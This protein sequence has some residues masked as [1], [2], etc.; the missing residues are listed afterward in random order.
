MNPVT[1]YFNAEKFE[2][3][4]FIGIGI[5]AIMIGVILLMY[6][7][8]PF[9]RGISIP[10]IVLAIAQVIVGATVYVRSPKDMAR[11]ESIVKLEKSKLNTEEIPRMKT[12]MKNFKIYRYLE[13]SFMIVGLLLMFV[14]ND[15]SFKQGI[16]LGIFMQ[17]AL[18]LSLDFFAERRG[19]EY[20]HYLSSISF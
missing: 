6:V 12:V 8:T 14:W 1:H 13:I 17:S 15:S 18:L 19:E 2:S 4:F 16:G 10:L 11:V 3:L 7:K 20:L 5:I 9:S